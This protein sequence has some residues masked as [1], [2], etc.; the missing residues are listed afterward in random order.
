M[1]RSARDTVYD[2]LRARLASGHY[3]PDASLIPAVLSEEFAVS[4]TPVREALGLLERDGLLVA[5]TRGFVIRRRSDEEI[6]EIFEVRAVLD[7]AAAFA[8]AGRHSP[9]DLARLDELSTQARRADDAATVRRL[10][11]EWHDG[12]RRA[13]HND[14]I[15]ALLRTLDAQVKLSAPWRTPAT[16]SD[17]DPA[18][19]DSLREHDAVLEAVRAGDAEL[20]RHRMLEHLAHDRD[21]RIRQ[22]VAPMAQESAPADGG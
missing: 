6:L 19:A 5:T 21:T 22:L 13:A 11:N 10:L 7:S 14:T 9:I 20:A 17:A 16:P 4:R 1:A 18:F 3:D 15:S 12:I 8:A 2:T